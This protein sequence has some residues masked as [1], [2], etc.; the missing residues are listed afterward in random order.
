MN[1]WYT[2]IYFDGLATDIKEETA[3]GALVVKSALD[4]VTNLQ[5][6]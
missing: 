2:G 1:S 5:L 4:Y 6:M 3:L